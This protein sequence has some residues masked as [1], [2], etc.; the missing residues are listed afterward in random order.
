MSKCRRR[1]EDGRP[2][3]K[4]DDQL[5]IPK[6]KV[7][8]KGGVKISQCGNRTPAKRQVA[9]VGMGI[10]TCPRPKVE[11]CTRKYAVAKVPFE[12]RILG[13]QRAEVV[14]IVCVKVGCPGSKA[15]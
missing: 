12:A 10:C 9:R 6:D 13:V 8:P 1:D 3:W 2:R 11:G 7:S 5:E 4:L 15:S 14:D